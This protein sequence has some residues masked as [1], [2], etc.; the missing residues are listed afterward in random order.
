VNIIARYIAEADPPLLMLWIHDG[1]HR[2]MHIKIIEQYRIA[3]RAALKKIGIYKLIDH[4]IDLHVLF[5][6]P[7]SPDNG[8]MYLALEQA[9]DDKTLTKPGVLA[10]DSLIQENRVAKFYNQPP[11]K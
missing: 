10:D 8:N 4:D 7:S 2:R 5:V 3:I 11:K 1:P 9:L 6:N